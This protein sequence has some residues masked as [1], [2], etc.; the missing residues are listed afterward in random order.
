MV[1]TTECNRILQKCW[2]AGKSKGIFAVVVKI[3]NKSKVYAVIKT[4][5]IGIKRHK[6]IKTDANP[7]MKEYSSYFWERRN[8]KN[9]KH[10]LVP[11]A[12]RQMR[13]ALYG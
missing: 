3:K 7:Y 13:L 10:L 12:S 8:V 5:A 4:S 9:S 2:F 6:K 11:S 1:A